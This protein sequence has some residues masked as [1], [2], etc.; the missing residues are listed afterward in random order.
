MKLLVN[1]V[2]FIIL[3]LIFIMPIVFIWKRKHFSFWS[4]LILNIF[5]SVFLIFFLA[6]FDDYS[7]NL[8]L[9]YYNFNFNALS[10]T[11]Q[12][13]G[14]E[15]KNLNTVKKLYTSTF[16]I[17]WPVKAIIM[18]ISFSPILLIYFLV[19]F[20]IRRKLNKNNKYFC[21]SK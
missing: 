19:L 1:V 10:E 6:W 16:G 20:F 8:L 2:F 5:T 3:L 21:N 13:K 7:K 9:E 15:P 17:G 18:M 14:V 4:Y 11:E 12:L